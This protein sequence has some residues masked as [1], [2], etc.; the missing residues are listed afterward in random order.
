MSQ[1][2]TM[3]WDATLL[4]NLVTW[5]TLLVSVQVAIAGNSMKEKHASANSLHL[6]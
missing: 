6:R 3:P 1:A 2:Y 4:E 5:N